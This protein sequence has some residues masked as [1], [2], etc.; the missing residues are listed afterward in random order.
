MGYEQKYKE[1][2]ERTKSWVRGEHPE[3]FSEAQKAAEF[4]FPEL[5]ESEDERIREMCMRYLDREYQHCPSDRK[6]IE[7]CIAWL[8]KR[9]NKT[10]DCQQNHQDVKY[11]NGG[12]VMEDFNGGEGFYKLHLDYLNKKQVEEVEEM[13]RT[14]NKES[15]ASDENIKNC[16]GMCLTDANEQRFNDYGTTLK[17]CIAWL[18][19]QRK[20]LDSDKVIEWLEGMLHASVGV[21]VFPSQ[22]LIDKFKKDF[23]L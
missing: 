1:A 17:N 3:C 23:E 15:N 2:L 22:R 11:P 4:I 16:I 13:V 21:R 18:E 9:C 14:W 19:K 12:I 5:K 7:K 10:V 8:E 20:K 6:N